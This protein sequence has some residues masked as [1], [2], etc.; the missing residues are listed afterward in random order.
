MKRFILLIHLMA[1]VCVNAQMRSQSTSSEKI[2]G[3]W[4][5]VAD[6]GSQIVFTK[7][8]QFN[9][10]MK[11]LMASF[12][13]KIKRDTLI[14]IDKTNSEVYRY[15]ITSLTKDALTLKFI[16]TGYMIEYRRKEN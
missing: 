5:G 4:I 3:K 1:C 9:Y 12:N 13:Y 14:A 2:V 8:E 16:R 6:K 15:L 7:T 11:Q 10:Y